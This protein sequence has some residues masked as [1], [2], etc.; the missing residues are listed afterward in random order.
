MHAEE[1]AFTRRVLAGVQRDAASLR[2]GAPAGS[3]Q[4]ADAERVEVLAEELLHLPTSQLLG[5][6]ALHSKVLTLPR[7]LRL[8]ISSPAASRQLTWVLHH[9]FSMLP[10]LEVACAVGAAAPTATSPLEDRLAQQ[11]ASHGVRI[12]HWSSGECSRRGGSCE[13]L[14]W[15]QHV[16]AQ[17][18]ERPLHAR[19][20]SP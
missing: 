20:P 1:A 7:V 3:E 16:T 11:L 17:M 13:E 6:P 2:Q 19:R 10:L 8:A 15:A 5:V 4:A 9:V 14:G 12:N 18:L